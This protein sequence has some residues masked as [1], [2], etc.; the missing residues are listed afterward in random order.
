VAPDSRD[1][2]M[3]FFRYRI[4]T[5]IFVVGFVTAIVMGSIYLGNRPVS[6]DVK[7]S[8][9]I[10]ATNKGDEVN[11]K[12]EALKALW[13]EHGLTL[14]QA[15]LNGTTR[16][17]LK[18]DIELKNNGSYDYN[19]LKLKLE[20]IEKTHK[21][22]HTDTHNVL[23][24]IQ[25]TTKDWIAYRI[26]TEESGA[27]VPCVSGGTFRLHSFILLP[28]QKVIRREGCSFNGAMTL[29]IKSIQAVKLNEVAFINLS[30]IVAPF[31]L[32]TRLK[33]GHKAI[34]S[35]LPACIVADVNR[36]DKNIKENA[37]KWA[38]YIEFF[39]KNNCASETVP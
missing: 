20:V 31:G 6:A 34:K 17:P 37:E 5:L 7:I 11:S 33:R 15:D 26:V 24:H 30:R 21:M 39:S 1:G 23:L 9:T 2:K 16:F 19:G 3:F 36:I 10:Q 35:K 4:H 27:Y 8:E 38:E 18:K 12:F 13:A 28:N 14:T 29:N 32:T 22:G 25:N